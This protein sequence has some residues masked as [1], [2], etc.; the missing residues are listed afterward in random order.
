MSV[1]GEKEGEKNADTV[2][3]ELPR[4]MP[5]ASETEVHLTHAYDVMRGRTNR[6]G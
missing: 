2:F 4:P 3:Q 6:F 1:D 5:T